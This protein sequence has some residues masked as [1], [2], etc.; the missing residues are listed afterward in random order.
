MLRDQ[1]SRTVC[2]FVTRRGHPSFFAVIVVILS[3]I[4]FKIVFSFWK[5][6]E[7]HS[8]EF[9]EGRVWKESNFVHSQKFPHRQSRVTSCLVMVEKPLPHIPLQK[10]ELT[11][12]REIPAKLETSLPYIILFLGT[13]SFPL[14]IYFIG[15]T[16]YMFRTVFPSI[17]RSYRLYILQQAYVKQILV[18]AC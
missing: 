5:R 1:R 6:R 8:A 15:V 7:S 3:I 12:L 11:S 4:S 9:G 2:S 18:T 10:C 17:V 13:T 14:Q 16:L